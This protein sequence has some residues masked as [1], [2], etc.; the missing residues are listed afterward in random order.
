MCKNS[1]MLKVGTVVFL[2][3]SLNAEPRGRGICLVPCCIQHGAHPA[4]LHVGLPEMGGIRGSDFRLQ[5]VP[6]PALAL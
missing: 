3:S 6:V 5:Q 2:T 4:C 1:E